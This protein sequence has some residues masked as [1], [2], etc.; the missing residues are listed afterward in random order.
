M[1]PADLA[2]EVPLELRKLA[3]AA[4]TANDA[5]PEDVRDQTPDHII[6]AVIPAI[7]ADER[8]TVAAERSGRLDRLQRMIDEFEALPGDVAIPVSAI[9]RRVEGR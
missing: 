4:M 8:A 7:R 3:I 9:R 5:L 6:A 2:G 1:T